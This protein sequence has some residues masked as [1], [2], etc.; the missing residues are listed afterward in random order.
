MRGGTYLV[1]R[2]I[3][4]LVEFW[5]R[6]NLDEQE[7][8]IGRHKGIGAPMGATHEFDPLPLDAEGRRR[9]AA[10]PIDAHVRLAAPAENRRRDRSCGAGTRSPTGSTRSPAR[11]TPGCLF[12]A[13]QR[14]PETQFVRVQRAL[15]GVDALNE[16]IKH[17]GSAIFAVPGGIAPGGSVGDLLLA[18][19]LD[20]RSAFRAAVPASLRTS[21]AALRPFAPVTPPPGCVPAPHRYRPRIGVR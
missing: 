14:D 6:T 2:R 5:D 7:R 9:R 16:Y 4:I 18:D 12:I 10:I 15:A 13:M 21:R 20:R 3:R 17:V 19:A 1:F 11:S 8:T